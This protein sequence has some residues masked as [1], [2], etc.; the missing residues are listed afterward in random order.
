[1][2]WAGG[3]DDLRAL[4]AVAGAFGVQTAYRDLTGRRRAARPEALVA[5]LRALG[6]PLARPGE[7]RTLLRDTRLAQ[8][9]RAL[10]CGLVAWGG[11]L[12]FELRGAAAGVRR[13]A[14][15]IVTEDGR[16][17]DPRL[18]EAAARVSGRPA[19]GGAARPARWLVAQELLPWG[20]HVLML[21][22]SRADH[23]AIVFSA[24]RR[25]FGA[26]APARDLGVFA[27]VY[28]LRGEDDCGA[29]D[30]GDLED[31][32]LWAAG[33]GCRWFGTLPLLAIG[34][35]GRCDHSPYAPLSRLFLS[36][37]YLDLIRA[38][39]LVP[40]RPLR[41]VI[42]SAIRSRGSRR[43]GALVDYP[44]VLRLKRRALGAIAAAVDGGPLGREVDAFLASDA[45]L[46]DYAAFRAVAEQRGAAWPRWPPRLREGR[47]RRGD[48][49]PAAARVH[50]CA[51][52]LL[53]RQLRRTRQR[54][55]EAGCDLYLDLP[56]GVD[57]LGYDAW[58]QREQFVEG[59]ELGAPP[60]DFFD[61]GQRW[62]VPPIHPLRSGAAGHAYLR[63]VLSRHA[64]RCGML[65]IDHVM[66]LHRLFWVPQGFEPADGVY[67]RYPAE[68]LYAVL[69]IESVRHAMRIVGENLG[70]VPAEVNRTMARRGILGLRVAQFEFRDDP[71]CVLPSPGAGAV[72]SLNTHDTPTFAG[73]WRAGDVALRVRLGLLEEP[74]A[75]LER[76]RRA[77]VRRAIAKRLRRRG[78]LRSARPTRGQVLAALLEM[79]CES[80]ADVVLVS[81]EDLWL[82]ERPQ[83][84]PG[85]GR[86][87]ES[88]RGRLARTMRSIRGDRGL[89]ALLRR[90]AARR[91]S[92]RVRPE[93]RIPSPR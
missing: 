7:A 29:G 35:E 38:A 84:V 40:S 8:E 55:A 80:P 70:T 77:L 22:A 49:D 82:E 21:R 63:E 87:Y 57:P 34:P 73:F 85:V 75:R 45:R 31:L 58:R 89:E 79:L 83:N 91:R 25:C 92:E 33:A 43:S 48:F 23:R 66:G 65:R 86:Q 2:A 13:L 67:V 36:E 54:M 12:R 46:G 15:E 71:S 50:V 18:R 37:L 6:A 39:D 64:R 11:R 76:R 27:P 53:D 28:G 41:A 17:L 88:W 10:H 81:L 93:P 72:W 3:P 1:M 74:R 9:R 4:R 47:L 90:L 68:E 30:L 78:F 44:R 51:Q 61:R 42:E 32:A 62:G 59:I 26:D 20:V 56:V 16:M 60:D 24:P 19:D 5:V 52:W 69:A 14:A